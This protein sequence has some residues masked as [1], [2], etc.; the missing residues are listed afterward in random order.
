VLTYE[1]GIKRRMEI[2]ACYNPLKEVGCSTFG[3]NLGIVLVWMI[4]A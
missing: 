3:E 1:V 2:F 4:G